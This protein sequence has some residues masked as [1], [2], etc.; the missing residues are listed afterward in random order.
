MMAPDKNNDCQKEQVE[1]Q[2]TCWTALGSAIYLQSTLLG[3]FRDRARI[4]EVPRGPETVQMTVRE[5]RG[6]RA[7]TERAQP[8]IGIA[9]KM[10]FESIDLI[11]CSADG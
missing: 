8:L 5:D 6:V 9:T 4:D 2:K 11:S 3:D 10:P 1:N 7:R